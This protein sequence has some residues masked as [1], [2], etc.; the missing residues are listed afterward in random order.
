MFTF[1]YYAPSGL[2]QANRRVQA[3]LAGLASCIFRLSLPPFR[4]LRSFY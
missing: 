1:V 2:V 4:Q 3:R